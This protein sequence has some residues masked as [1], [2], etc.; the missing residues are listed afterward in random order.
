MSPHYR[1]AAYYNTAS[2]LY[3]CEIYYVESLYYQDPDGDYDGAILFG[4]FKK[5]VEIADILLN[6]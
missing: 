5:N 3:P 6:L 1:A 2:S 4:S